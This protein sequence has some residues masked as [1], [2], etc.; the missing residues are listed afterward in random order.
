MPKLAITE[1]QTPTNLPQAGA[2]SFG[3]QEGAAARQMGRT[4]QQ[5]ASSLN[6]ALDQRG[7]RN[8][9]AYQA[10]LYAL[11]QEVLA[12]PDMA[13]R[14]DLFEQG[15]RQLNAKH[16]KGIGSTAAFDR[17]V[18]MIDQRIG[19][20]FRL[21]NNLQMVE[22]GQTDLTDH[23]GDLSDEWAMAAGD[24]D[25]RAD[26]EDRATAAIRSAIDSGLID[27]RMGQESVERFRRRGTRAELTRLFRED[28]ESALVMLRNPLEGIDEGER[29]ELIT[30]GVAAHEAYLRDERLRELEI[31]KAEEAEAAARKEQVEQELVNADA[32]GQ[33]SV[34]LVQ[35][36]VP[37][38]GADDGR[39][40]LDR[41]RS[42]GGGGGPGGNRADRT[43]YIDLDEKAR[44]GDPTVQKKIIQAYADGRIT[45]SMYDELTDAQLSNRWGRGRKHLYTSLDPG[46]VIL[47]DAGAAA[48]M[49]SRRAQAEREFDAFR[50]ANPDATVDEVMRRADH[51]AKTAQ[52]IDVE[53]IGAFNLR[54]SSLVQRTVTVTGA[55]GKQV[56]R[57]V[58]DYEA[59]EDEITS[60]VESG[61]QSAEW[62]A[63]EMRLLERLQKI[64]ERSAQVMA[65]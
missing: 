43:L 65:E 63:L 8:A 5:A 6:A 9:S 45:K 32:K 59:T 31:R 24:P 3:A 53:S 52:D 21:K 55:D 10:D 61:E 54:P 23:L 40:W 50:E 26:V 27:E 41:A 60:A 49:A 44:A 28:P 29:Q 25:A 47:Q 46:E 16:R 39:L 11:E 1:D 13:K 33:L 57:T 12:T 48:V 36:L 17:E 42:G 34:S 56:N 15:K 62:G 58:Y 7:R 14:G 22:Q 64:D 51:I 20:D 30:R 35:S 37:V 38:L 2:G 4:I 18:G 19:A